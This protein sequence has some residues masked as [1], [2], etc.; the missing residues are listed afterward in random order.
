MIVGS[1]I[2]SAIWGTAMFSNHPAIVKNRNTTQKFINTLIWLS[3]MFWWL[4]GDV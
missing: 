1:I 4:S 3:F 2:A